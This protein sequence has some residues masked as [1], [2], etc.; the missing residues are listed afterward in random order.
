[1]MIV[2]YEAGMNV[3]V[4]QGTWGEFEYNDVF[5]PEKEG[6]LM[7]NIQ[8]GINQGKLLLIQVTAEIEDLYGARYRRHLGRGKYDVIQGKKLNIVA[9]TKDEAIALEKAGV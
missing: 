5:N 6:M 4:V 7:Q 8:A 3:Q 2:K 1:M 9:L